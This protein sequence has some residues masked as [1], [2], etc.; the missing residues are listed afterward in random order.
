MKIFLFIIALIFC[1]CGETEYQK[2]L[3]AEIG[4][5][6]LEISKDSSEYEWTKNYKDSL[7]MVDNK[8]NSDILMLNSLIESDRNLERQLKT[9]RQK[10]TDLELELA[11]TK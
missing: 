10:R 3:K 4:K 8:S 5:I 2:K 11:K 7:F 1:S 9:G 6:N